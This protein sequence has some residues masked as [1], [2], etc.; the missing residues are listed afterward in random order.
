LS[1]QATKITS[2]GS[3][4]LTFYTFNR[5]K[6]NNIIAICDVNINTT[7]HAMRAQKIKNQ[8]L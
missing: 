5:K 7:H 8:Y 6:I 4:R 1:E 2:D 3:K